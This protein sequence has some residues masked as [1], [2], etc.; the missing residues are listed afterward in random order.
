[1]KNITRKLLYI[2][3]MALFLIILNNTKVDASSAYLTSSIAEPSEGESVTV[4]ANVTAGAWNL[5]LTGAGQSQVIYGYTQTNANASDSKSITFVAG[6]AG[7][8]YTFALIG[9]MTDIS[10][11]NS[12][13]VNQ[14]LTITVKGNNTAPNVEQPPV[15]SEPQAKSSEARLSNLGIRPNDFKGFKRNTT[16]YNVEVPNNVA[17]V[18]V[19]AVPVDK[20]ATVTG[21]GKVA[22]KEG[23]N[24]VNVEVTAEDGTTKKTY[25]LNITRLTVAQET[26]SATEARLKNL[27]IN[28]KEY[29]FSGF[30]RDTMSYAVQVPN[31][32]AEIEVYAETVSSKATITGTGKVAL[33]E[34]VNN[35][36]VEVTAEDGKTKQIYTIEITRAA[37]EVVSET[38]ST[39]EPVSPT[40]TSGLASLL[41]KNGN[42]SPKFNTN[43]YEYTI[44]ITEDISSL[45][46]EAK[47]NNENDTLEIIGNENLQQGENIITILVTNSETE[48]TTTYQI[49]V[50]KNIIKEV[51]G[52]V[53][54]LK[55]STWGYREKII[56]SAIVILI[57]VI[58]VAVIVK[59]KLSNEDDG[60]DLPGADE[61]DKALIEHQELAEEDIGNQQFEED[62]ENQETQENEDMQ[63]DYGEKAEYL[64]AN[65]GFEPY[66]KKRGKHDF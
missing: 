57:A 65:T 44:G 36:Q 17:E 43:T 42:L 62:E 54:W 58:V 12:E 47:A 20:K 40:G 35:V 49:I 52:K 34:G 41:V 13:Q 27:G 1:M 9:D 39:D 53:N 48:E 7:T 16:T 51:V 14:V 15:T 10:S 37:S 56:V 28:P 24:K 60:F 3:I 31:N 5:T 66:S 63:D 18:E 50:N 25:T 6:S 38:P 46:I 32:V 29:D 33:K 23:A 61:L 64:Q 21:T 4:T 22:L 11:E 2:I 19:Y 30:K 45:D 8:T 59:V 55:P 26:S